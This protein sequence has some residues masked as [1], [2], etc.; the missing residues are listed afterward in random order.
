[1]ETPHASGTCGPA[2]WRRRGPAAGVLTIG[3]RAP[4]TPPRRPSQDPDR[5]G[6]KIGSPEPYCRLSRSSASRS[7]PDRPGWRYD[8]ARVG[9]WIPR[10]AGCTS[11]TF[12]MWYFDRVR[13][14]ARGPGRCGPG[15][16]RRAGAGLSDHF[17]ALLRFPGAR[18][19]A[20]ITQDARGVFEVPP[21]SLPRGRAPGARSLVVVGRPGTAPG[22]PPLRAPASTGGGEETGPPRRFPVGAL[23][24]AGR[25]SAE[26]A[27]RVVERPSIRRRRA[28][29]GP[30]KKARKAQSWLCLAAERIDAR[31]G[32]EIEPRALTAARGEGTPGQVLSRGSG[33]S[34]RPVADQVHGEHGQ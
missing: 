18:A 7:R 22:S 24:G 33:R 9:S 6:T 19:H 4:A 34:R 12:V 2:C 16:G 28:P 31:G 26:Q 25:S 17:T 1:M 8:A 15:A 5:R 29:A 11:S 30:P 20:V 10:G 21:S 3:P 27:R 23:G 13:R 14:S 32:R